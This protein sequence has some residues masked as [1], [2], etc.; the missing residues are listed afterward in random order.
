MDIIRLDHSWTLL[1]HLRMTGHLA[2]EPLTMPAELQ[3]VR[4]EL[5]LNNN[6]TL[7][8]EDRRKFGRMILTQTPELILDKYGT[9][10]MS[11]L[12]NFTHFKKAL[13]RSAMKIKPLLLSQR[14]VA[15]L[16]NIYADD[17][18][19]A[20]K[21][22]PARPSSSLNSA[23]VQ[24]LFESIQTILADAIALKGTSFDGVVQQGNYQGSL[25]IFHRHGSPCFICG[26]EIQQIRLSGRSTH[27]CPKCQK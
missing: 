11:E 22:H 24:R 14:I 19:F 17:C 12:F 6:T 15:G 13:S 10:P 4:A 26:C 27:Y 18:C 8:F 3:R 16:G 23:E 25:K 20:A 1:I 9:D 2:V 7:R 5:F 21:I